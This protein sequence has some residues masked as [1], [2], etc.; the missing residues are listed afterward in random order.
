[1]VTGLEPGRKGEILGAAAGVFAE[2]G[3]DGGSMRDIAVRVGV[4]EP[5][6]YRHFPGKE[7]LFLALMR[8]GG[9]GACAT[10]PSALVDG[11]R[12]ETM[13]HCSSS[14]PS[15]TAA[16]HVRFYG[17]RAAHGPLGS[18]PQPDPSSRSTGA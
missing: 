5:A 9:A 6:L 12:P 8:A 17:P 13:R 16:A 4:T 2:R 1:M 15:P 14:P 10:R 18:R 7:A 11:V 3:Y